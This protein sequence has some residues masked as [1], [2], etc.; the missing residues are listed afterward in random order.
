MSYYRE[1][2]WDEN[3]SIF[4][5]I[6]NQNEKKIFIIFYNTYNSNIH[7]PFIRSFHVSSFKWIRFFDP[8]E[9][10]T[11]KVKKHQKTPVKCILNSKTKF[12]SINAGKIQ[13]LSI[14]LVRSV[15]NLKIKFNELQNFLLIKNIINFCLPT[16]TERKYRKYSTV[17]RCLRS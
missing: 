8:S 6:K 9:K 12:Q 4:F 13:F 7:S 15:K 5:L 14:F 17:C 1:S 16:E 10:E 3:C 2:N 11:A